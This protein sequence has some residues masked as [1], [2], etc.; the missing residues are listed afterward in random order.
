[1]IRIYR[2]IVHFTELDDKRGRVSNLNHCAWMRPDY[3]EA[4]LLCIREYHRA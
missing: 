3:Q 1:M 2:D 4:H